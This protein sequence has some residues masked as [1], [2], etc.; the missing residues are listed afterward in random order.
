MKPSDDGGL[1]I[2][3]SSRLQRRL[4]QGMIPE[5]REFGI[6]MEETDEEILAMPFC[7]VMSAYNMTAW[8]K[9]FK[10]AP[11]KP[12]DHEQTK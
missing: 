11:F 3:D 9:L 6:F 10:P 5:F 1:A 12:L 7:M 2:L 8:L 4:V